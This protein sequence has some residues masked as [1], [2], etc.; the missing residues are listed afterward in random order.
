MDIGCS[1]QIEREITILLVK[2]AAELLELLDRRRTDRP[3][4]V[5]LGGKAVGLIE[6]DTERRLAEGKESR[7]PAVLDVKVGRVVLVVM[8]FQ[9]GGQRKI[10]L[11]SSGLNL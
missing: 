8:V 2:L 10:Q 7:Q 9:P 11:S 5:V 3:A 1:I 4:V 6:V